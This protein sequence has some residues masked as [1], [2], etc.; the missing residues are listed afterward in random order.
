[1]TSCIYFFAGANSLNFL[2]YFYFFKY[3]DRLATHGQHS[4]HLSHNA[5]NLH[6]TTSDGDG[7]SGGASVFNVTSAGQCTGVEAA[8][9]DQ[10]KL[11]P[12]SSS[13]SSTSAATAALLS[14][15]TMDYVVKV[16]W[17]LS[18]AVTAGRLTARWF[19]PSSP[20]SSAA[21][22]K[23]EEDKETKLKWTKKRCCCW[24]SYYQLFPLSCTPPMRLWFVYFCCLFFLF[25]LYLQNKK[26]R[27]LKMCE[28]MREE[29]F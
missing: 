11:F 13:S 5:H 15:S 29:I 8:I 23:Q 22:V 14:P 4:T 2:F 10:R 9:L 20:L 24:F 17:L 3:R 6:I 19:F 18:M 26:L 12:S 28:K 25:F 21:K 7:N 27:I 1:M 16:F